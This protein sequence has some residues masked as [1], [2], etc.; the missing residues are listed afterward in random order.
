MHKTASFS[1][2]IA[3]VLIVAT[4]SPVLAAGDGAA[5]RR[6]AETWCAGCHLLG[7]EN[8]A[9]MADVPSFPVIAQQKTPDAIRAFL[10]NPH[11][12]MPQFRL[13]RQ[14]IEDLVQFITEL[15]KP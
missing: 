2:R 4:A 14:D 10:F 11:P 7:D 13:T 12:P 1:L 8:K 9:A 15:K 3:A 6:T 5:G